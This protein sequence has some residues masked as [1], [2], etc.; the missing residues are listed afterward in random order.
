MRWLS[1]VTYIALSAKCFASDTFDLGELEGAD[2]ELIA[3][4]ERATAPSGSDS[5][6]SEALEVLQDKGKAGD[7]YAALVCGYC[8]ENAVGIPKSIGIAKVAYKQAA[9]ADLVA[10]MRRY[11]RLL[12]MTDGLRPSQ[13]PDFAQA[14]EWLKKAAE[15]GDVLATLELGRMDAAGEGLSKPDLDRAKFRLNAAAEAG[16][17]DA[18]VELGRL[19]RAPAFGT[20]PDFEEALAWFQKAADKGDPVGMLEAG[21]AF[22]RGEGVEA[23]LDRALFLYRSAADL[24]LP[25]AWFQLGTCA[26]NGVGMKVDKKQALEWYH[27]AADAKLPKAIYQ[28]AV[29]HDKGEGGLSA[30]PKKATILLH[31]AA[32]L[33]D[34]SAQ[35]QLGLR[36]QHGKLAKKDEALAVK[37][38]SAGAAQRFNPA[39]VNLGGM[40]ETGY[41]KTIKKDLSI[42]VRLYTEAAKQH[43]PVA[44]FR[45][46]RLYES[47]RGVGKDLV[48]AYVLAAES[49]RRGHGPSATLRDQIRKQLTPGQLETAESRLKQVRQSE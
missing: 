30:D 44:Q 31:Q 23:D 43:D 3:L 28:V 36:Y 12:R 19:H 38:L 42:A 32:E 39:M 40:Y 13:V 6:R 24:E 33:D 17:A 46:S 18:M 34:P 4:A 47:G 9:E 35:N 7:P 49:A 27:K 14:R 41:G 26:A 48:A 25:E 29:Y 11:G 22:Q 8:M 10:G 2:S 16:S 21:F 37:W 45:L 1:L 20:K 5:V 15:K